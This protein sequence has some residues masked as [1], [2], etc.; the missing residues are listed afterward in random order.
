ME[1]AVFLDVGF[2]DFI[3]VFASLSLYNECTVIS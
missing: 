2:S 1:V 3:C